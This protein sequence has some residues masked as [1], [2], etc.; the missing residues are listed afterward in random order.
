MNG[1]SAE[2][3]LALSRQQHVNFCLQVLR[4]IEIPDGQ[5]D[6]YAALEQAGQEGLSPTSLAAAMHRTPDKVAGVLGALGRRINGT[7]G[8]P[9]WKTAAIE[10]FFE[11]PVHGRTFHYV[12]R[13]ELREALGI[14]RQEG[15]L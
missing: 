7:T 3:S 13:P 11:F 14:A 6:L 4:R 5:R 12:M 10:L 1:V 15:L 9:K 2:Q 8:V